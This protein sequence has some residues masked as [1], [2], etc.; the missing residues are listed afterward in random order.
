MT[1]ITPRAF[2]GGE[3]HPRRLDRHV[4]SGTDRD[5]D[6]GAR[7]SGASSGNPPPG[8]LKHLAERTDAQL[9][10]GLELRPARVA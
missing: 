3:D 2:A 6:V 10:R 1:P 8:V 4:G 5:A 7:Q 9:L